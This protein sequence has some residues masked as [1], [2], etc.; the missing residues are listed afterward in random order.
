MSLQTVPD[1]KQ[2]ALEVS[3]QRLEELAVL[4]ILDRALVQPDHAARARQAG[5]DR[6]VRPVEVELDDRRATNGRPGAHACGPLAVARLVDE[7]DQS[8]V[9][10]GFFLSA[11]QVSILLA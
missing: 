1:D 7:D 11:G 2:P 4:L 6:N 10:L 3:T 8:P 5:D 9:A